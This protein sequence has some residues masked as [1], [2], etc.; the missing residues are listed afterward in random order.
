M[1]KFL[2]TIAVVLALSACGSEKQ[3]PTAPEAPVDSLAGYWGRWRG[4]LL[5]RFEEPGK[6]VKLFRDNVDFHLD[7]E[8]GLTA[9]T[10]SGVVYTAG[11]ERIDKLEIAILISVDGLPV[12]LTAKRL[13]ASMT[14]TAVFDDLPGLTGVWTVRKFGSGK[15]VPQAGPASGA[16]TSLR[17]LL[18]SVRR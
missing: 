12:H 8:A 15:P 2:V 16:D 14:G 6:P 1:F 11:I 18:S 7:G 13:G 5:S 17:Y 4:E 3:R 9:M 10:I